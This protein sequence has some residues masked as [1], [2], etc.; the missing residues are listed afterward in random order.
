[1]ASRCSICGREVPDDVGEL[2]AACIESK[3]KQRPDTHGGEVDATLEIESRRPATLD[4]PAVTVDS[5]QADLPHSAVEDAT[6][7]PG[8]DR[9][10][11]GEAPQPGTNVRYFGDYELLEEI[12]RGGMGVVY[13]A[14]QVSLNR[15]VALK[16]ILAGQ[17]ASEQDVQR[18]RTEAEAAANLDHPGIVPIFEIGEHEGQPFFSMGFVE[19]TSLADRLTE[20]PLPP[21]EAADLTMKLATAVAFAHERNVIHRD[22]KPANVL[23]DKNGDPRITDFGLAKKLEADSNLTGTG[24]ILGTP[25][26]MP[27]EQAAGKS[28]EVTPAADVYAL[29][30]VLYALLTGRPPFQA[31]SPMDTLLQVLSN[32]PVPPRQLD[33][34]IPR[35]LETICLKCLSKESAQ[36]YL[37]AESLAVDLAR[38][39]RGEPIQARPVGSITRGWRWCRRN[40]VVASLTTALIMALLLGTGASTYLAIVARENAT[41]ALQQ[42]D[43]AEQQLYVNQIASSLREWQSGNVVAAERS[44]NACDTRLRGWEHAYLHG[45]INS[46]QR[47]MSGPKGEILDVSVSDDGRRIFSRSRS[48]LG[49]SDRT[50]RIW[51][52]A[53]GREIEEF[54]DDTPVYWLCHTTN[55]QRVLCWGN[56]Q[57]CVRNA[58]TG[59]VTS[60][61]RPKHFHPGSPS[62]SLQFN[63]HGSRILGVQN[64]EA[65]LWDAETG[66]ELF[67]LRSNAEKL[68][69]SPD[70]NQITAGEFGSGALKLTSWNTATGE[71]TLKSPHG[72]SFNI[73]RLV[74]SPNGRQLAATG[75]RTNDMTV[76][77]ARTGQVVFTQEIHS[78]GALCTVFSRDGSRIATG[79]WDESLKIWDAATGRLLATS[80]GHTAGV[81]CA[82]FSP[83]GKRIASGDEDGVLKIWDVDSGAELG[84]YSGHRD[85][86]NSVVFHPDGIHVV[87][88]SRDKTLKI[89]TTTSSKQGELVLQGHEN[90]VRCASFSPDGKQITTGG[91]KSLRIWDSVS[92]QQVALM[93]GHGGPRPNRGR[94]NAVAFSA[95]G[96]L[97]VSGGEDKTLRVWNAATGEEQFKLQSLNPV[98]AVRFSSDTTEVLGCAPPLL[99]WW[100]FGTREVT[101]TMAKGWFVSGGRPITAWTQTVARAISRLE[102]LDARILAISPHNQSVIGLCGPNSVHGDATPI[103]LAVQPR[104]PLITLK[105]HTKRVSC[106]AYSPDGER[107]VTGSGN[108]TLR[109]WD[110]KTGFEM[111]TLRGHS[112]AITSVA[113]SPDGDSIVSSSEDTTVRVWRATPI[114]TNDLNN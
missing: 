97:V 47:T 13:K 11:G 60:R 101:R 99:K 108:S 31:A 80:A 50:T 33:S 102:Q 53:T 83:D 57:L 114:A 48:P 4:E 96:T 37:D 25:S 34:A 19:G 58:V 41:Q 52:F 8:S 22:L 45:L 38:F 85:C 67:E 2:C 82:S 98:T 63:E 70:G 40:P 24:Q 21:R 9:P 56:G 91:L 90:A 75:V 1:M 109:L 39:Q 107:I 64:H 54:A 7:P 71:R 72:I 15:I 59:E 12:A 68:L 84:S 42:R 23:L 27:P 30:A 92:G 61:F 104:S 35:D 29:G 43:R 111:L 106:V 14:R 74:F 76:F 6:L 112:A 5:H 51:D 20:G 17:H 105:G 36:R 10:A 94:V 100:N 95:D 86:I 88:G 77:N 93:T 110:S 65:T 79:S 62:I 3:Q 69:L 78:R 87:T 55:G 73:D 44:W 103:V 66:N 18:F 26:Y 81:T 16:M 89:W 32:D 46:N 49:Q 113:F 28:E